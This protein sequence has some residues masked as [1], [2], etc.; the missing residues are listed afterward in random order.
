MLRIKSIQLTNRIALPA[1][2]IAILSVFM[3]V[4]GCDDNQGKV[5][6]PRKPSVSVIISDDS[7]DHLA[8][9]VD[10]SAGTEYH[11]YGTKMLTDDPERIEKIEAYT[12]GNPN[13]LLFSVSLD[14]T[15]RIENL[16]LRDKISYNSYVDNDTVFHSIKYVGT[17][18][19][20]VWQTLVDRSVTPISSIPY[21]KYQKT[22]ADEAIKGSVSVFCGDRIA[23]DAGEVAAFYT[24]DE[25]DGGHFHHVRLKRTSSGLYSFS[26]GK[27]RSNDGLVEGI[28]ELTCQQYDNVQSNL[29]DAINAVV[30]LMCIELTPPVCAALGIERILEI[31]INTWRET[32]CENWKKGGLPFYSSNGKLTVVCFL[33]DGSSVSESFDVAISNQNYLEMQIPGDFGVDLKK[34]TR[35]I[36]SNGTIQLNLTGNVECA[37]GQ[38]SV[39]AILESSAGLIAADPLDQFT[40][41]ATSPD[42]NFSGSLNTAVKCEKLAMRVFLSDAIS[43]RPVEVAYIKDIDPF[44]VYNWKHFSINGHSYNHENASAFSFGGKIPGGFMNSGGMYLWYDYTAHEGDQLG[45]IKL[46]VAAN[47]SGTDDIGTLN[48]GGDGTYLFHGN[49]YSVE[50]IR[51]EWKDNH[52]DDRIGTATFHGWTDVRLEIKGE[53]GK[54]TLSFSPT[55]DDDDPDKPV[56]PEAFSRT[57]DVE[58]NVR[59]TGFD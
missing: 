53:K 3:L 25:D 27:I 7:S 26:I 16:F 22:L 8:S 49:V 45:V 17:D 51:Y 47:P 43:V 36:Q 31:M 14:S 59:V 46:D 10:S 44:D 32:D 58:T 12:I 54:M 29:A 4:A 28:T 48:C 30:A 13:G 52:G 5:D 34:L 35:K 50:T 24:P 21:S 11:F 41:A 2:L 18:T 9:I 55:G 37:S 40:K 6:Q 19:I 33:N 15:N 1:A 42:Y 23:T 20:A 57:F 39:T 56:H 38:A